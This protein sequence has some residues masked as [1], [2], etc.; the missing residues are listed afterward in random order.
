[1]F[2][3]GVDEEGKQKI[4]REVAKLVFGSQTNF[5]SIGMSS[6]SDTS[7]ESRGNPSK[8]GRDE[9]SGNGSSYLERFA[10]EVRKNPHRVFYVEDV[11]QLDQ[12][13]QKG[14][15]RAIERG[16]MMMSDGEVVKIEDA[17]VIFSCE[18]FSSASRACS[19]PV[20]QKV[21]EKDENFDLDEA[22]SSSLPLDLNIPADYDTGDVRILE[23]VDKQI[24]F[25]IQV[26]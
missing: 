18:S 3:L 1:M 25:K 17:I 4:A 8:R 19:P 7:D 21:E 20:R 11:E 23:T 10:E 9:L 15:K 26:L 5:K 13:A 16:E 6:F 2:F 12:C 14:I 24:F 22:S